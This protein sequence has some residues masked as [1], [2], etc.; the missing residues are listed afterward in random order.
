MA[1]RADGSDRRQIEPESMPGEAEAE[2]L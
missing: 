1:V 2:R